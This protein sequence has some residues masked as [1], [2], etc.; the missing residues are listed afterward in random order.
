MIDA[1]RQRLPRSKADEVNI[2]CRY[3]IE[4]M[5]DPQTWDECIHEFVD[6]D[7]LSR[8]RAS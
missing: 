6:E 5:A 7:G 2:D 3:C 1:P 4:G 8:E